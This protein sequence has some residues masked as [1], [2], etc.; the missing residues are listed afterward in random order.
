MSGK[1]LFALAL[2]AA[3]YYV[4]EYVFEPMHLYYELPWI[5][6]PMHVIGGAASGIF[7]YF[8]SNRHHGEALKISLVATLIVAILWEFYEYYIDFANVN[9]WNGWGDTLSDIALGLVGAYIAISF[10]KKST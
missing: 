4:S 1:S 8:L 10:S 5:D 3:L 7:F 2:L 6:M 9:E